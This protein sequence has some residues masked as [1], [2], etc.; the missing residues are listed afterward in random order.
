MLSGGDFNPEIWG[1]SAPARG[2][3]GGFLPASKGRSKSTLR[4]WFS[5]GAAGRQRNRGRDVIYT[6]TVILSRLFRG[7]LENFRIR[8]EVV[9]K[10]G[11]TISRIYIYVHNVLIEMRGGVWRVVGLEEGEMD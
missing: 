9:V 3:A 1:G 7:I 4:S 5:P 11:D 6:F 8:F 2:G 10:Q